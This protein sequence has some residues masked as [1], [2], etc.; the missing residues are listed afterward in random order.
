MSFE[1]VP[2]GV[3]T[4]L[5]DIHTTQ[6]DIERKDIPDKP[7]KVLKGNA[8]VK[9]VTNKSQTKI[10]EVKSKGES[11]LQINTF[12][13]PGWETKIDSKKVTY[14]DNNKLKLITVDMPDGQHILN[15]E[16][17][18]TMPRAVGNALSL[19]MFFSLVAFYLIKLWKR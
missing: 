12:S 4:K 10:F 6:L 1:F 8:E 14:S 16:F 11:T 9:I 19:V 17:V 15:L 18:N 5:S 13:F 2:G 7:Y 3:A